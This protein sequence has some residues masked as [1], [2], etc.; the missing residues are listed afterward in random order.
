MIFGR[1]ET[2]YLREGWIPKIFHI[3][4]DDPNIFSKR[5][6]A[7]VFGVGNNMVAAI[8]YWCLATGIIYLDNRDG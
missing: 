2:F 4:G 8:K 1:H 6:A 7:E 5:E 3:L